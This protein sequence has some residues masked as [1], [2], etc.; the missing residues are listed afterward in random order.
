[1]KIQSSLISSGTGND[2]PIS[3]FLTKHGDILA[4]LPQELSNSLIVL[5]QNDVLPI[6]EKETVPKH[7]YLYHLLLALHITIL[8]ASNIMSALLCMFLVLILL[9]APFVFP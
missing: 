4:L 6:I 8:I 1:M 9:L 3:E 2:L 7:I 5:G